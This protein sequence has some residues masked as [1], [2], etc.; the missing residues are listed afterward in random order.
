MRNLNEHFVFRNVKR[1]NISFLAILLL[2]LLTVA[3]YPGTI[4]YLHPSA[5]EGKLVSAHCP[6]AKSVLLFEKQGVVVGVRATASFSR[7]DQVDVAITF[8]VPED[9]T[10][11]LI[12]NHIEAYVGSQKI[13]EAKLSVLVW[14]SRFKTADF[15][16]DSPLIGKTERSLFFEQVTMYGTTEHAYYIFKTS[17]TVPESETFMLKMPGFLVDNVKVELPIVKFMKTEEFAIQPL[18]C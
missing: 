18:N 16:P 3:C 4:S 13:S 14:K 10:V 11:Q 15:S 9:K 6:P 1:I 17:L 8:E 7:E 5:L 12:D 2:A